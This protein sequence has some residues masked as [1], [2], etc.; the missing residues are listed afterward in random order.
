MASSAIRKPWYARPTFWS[1][2]IIGWLITMPLADAFGSWVWFA[3]VVVLV[4]IDVRN[5]GSKGK[6]TDLPTTAAPDAVSTEVLSAA[7]P[8]TAVPPHV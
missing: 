6:P 5:P 1:L 4:A 3:L 2:I 8:H 7:K